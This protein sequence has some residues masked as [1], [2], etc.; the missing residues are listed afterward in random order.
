[1]PLIFK[2]PGGVKGK[3][4]GTPASLLDLYPTLIDLVGLPANED[5]EGTSLKPLL[6]GSADTSGKVAMTSYGYG[7]HAIRDDRY[8]YI[9]FSDGSEELYD[10]QNDPNEW[11]NLADNIDYDEIKQQLAHHLPEVSAPLSP[12]TSSDVTNDYFREILTKA[13]IDVKD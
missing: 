11:V 12:V 2:T 4:T 8:R 9:Y 3:V 6:E 5:N 1:V 10:H 13:G 7:N